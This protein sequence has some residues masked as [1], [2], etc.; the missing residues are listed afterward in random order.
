MIMKANLKW[1]AAVLAGIAA[2][3]CATT[4]GV[5][6]DSASTIPGRF[7]TSDGSAIC[8]PER[9]P[10]ARFE[11]FIDRL[12]EKGN[13]THTMREAALRWTPA[14]RRR[15]IVRAVVEAYTYG[16]VLKNDFDRL[17]QRGF[18]IERISQ[19]SSGGRPKYTVYSRLIA[20]RTVKNEL[21]ELALDQLSTD[22]EEYR[23]PDWSRERLLGA[24]KVFLRKYQE[25][26]DSAVASV[27]GDRDFLELALHEL[28]NLAGDV[29]RYYE[30]CDPSVIGSTDAERV[31]VIARALQSSRPVG[32]G[33]YKKFQPTREIVGFDI[34][35]IVKKEGMKEYLNFAVAG[36]EPQAEVVYRPDTGSKGNIVGGAFPKGVWALTYDDGPAKTTPQILD[37]LKTHGVKATFFVLSKQIEN[38]AFKAHALRAA[39]EGHAMA[40]HSYTHAQIPN[41]GAV[42]RE[43]EITTALKVFENIL[44]SKTSYFRLPYGAGVNVASVRQKLKEANV[45]HVFWNVDTLDWQDRDP[46]SILRRSLAQMKAVGNKG[47]ILFH[48]IHAQ[49]VIASEL[50]MRHLK[51]PANAICPVTI[52][53]VV[54]KM[55]AD[56]LGQSA[57]AL[58]P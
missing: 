32:P 20:L 14:E 23:R 22:L 21:V 4:S 58:C 30:S 6:K 44:G 1:V 38:S 43:K 35:S 34:E 33:I 13:W 50:V 54:D 5:G 57:P 10:D 17:V 29:E 3:S 41:L 15:A 16:E 48:D 37:H 53:A 12:V 52:P 49:S 51:D 24:V 26:I 27:N 11:K 56:A 8:T 9:E 19:R 28:K 47:V 40:S 2:S 7:I 55:N 36:R 31:D 18:T 42:G 45:I 39:A 25:E 46:Q